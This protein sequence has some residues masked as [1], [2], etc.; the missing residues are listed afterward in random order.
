MR[1]WGIFLVSMLLLGA[2]CGRLVRQSERIVVAECYD[3]KLYADELEGL[4]PSSAGKMDSVAQVNAFVDSWIRR[5]LL[6]HQ[7]EMNLSPEQ[8]DFT[9]QL[10]DYRNSLVIYAYETQLIE[11]NLDTLVSQEEIAAYYEEHKDNFQTRSTMVKLC[12]V[13]LDEDCRHMREFRQLLSDRDT[14]DM[15]RLSDLAAQYALSSF[16]DVDTWMRLDDLL[17]VVP[18]EIY[19]YDS[20]FRRNKFVTFEKDNLVYMLRFEDYLLEQSVSP[21]ELEAD[22]IRNI[23][24]LKRQKELL[25][26][27]HSDLYDQAR[28]EKVFEIY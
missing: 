12:Y 27:M 19:N 1:K 7:A 23:I 4:M 20:F 22:G 9:K 17:A 16:L 24:L 28:R 3:V 6:V 21:L 18:I 26:R 8:L 11:Q 15:P 2:G 25:A 10:Q 5:Q 14:L 13:V